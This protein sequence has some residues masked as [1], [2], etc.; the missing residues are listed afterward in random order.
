MSGNAPD[1]SVMVPT[2]A[3]EKVMVWVAPGAPVGAPAAS[4]L[5]IAWR[6]DPAPE[7]L[8]LVTTHCACAT[9]ASAMHPT[10]SARLAASIAR[11]VPT[12]HRRRGAIHSKPTVVFLAQIRRSAQLV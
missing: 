12:E 2:P 6:S 8:V 3:P 5:R 4:A 1:V 9:D 7:S 10:T 11:N